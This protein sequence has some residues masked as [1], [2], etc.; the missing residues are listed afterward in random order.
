MN[1]MHERET[2]TRFNAN[3]EEAAHH[4]TRGVNKGLRVAFDV[5][6]D[7]MLGARS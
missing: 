7:H 5:M 2:L 4:Y 1:G 6:A 3:E